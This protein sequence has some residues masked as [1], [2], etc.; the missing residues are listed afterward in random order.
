[1]PCKSDIV[2]CGGI[3]CVTADTAIIAGGYLIDCEI[4]IVECLGSVAGRYSHNNRTGAVISEINGR[5][6]GVECH[7]GKA[8][9]ES[10]TTTS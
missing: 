5:R 2:K 9:A 10:R 4:H 6:S 3:V 1:M 7:V 8:Y